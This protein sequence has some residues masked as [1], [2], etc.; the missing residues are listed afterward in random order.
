MPAGA[1]GTRTPQN[2]NEQVTVTVAPGAK[3]V[4]WA[5]E[6][7]PTADHRVLPNWDVAYGEYDNAG[8][9]EADSS[10]KAILRFRGPPQPYK[11]PMRSRLEP[12]VHFR[13]G[14][15]SGFLGPVQTIFLKD[16]SIEGFSSLI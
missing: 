4:Y 14:T 6:P 13:V 1:V 3:V 7:N 16:G 2:A 8:V 15:S 5:T 12:H 11:V 9:A 10:G